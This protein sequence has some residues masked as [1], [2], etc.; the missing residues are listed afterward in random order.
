MSLL[1]GVCICRWIAVFASLAGFSVYAIGVIFNKYR[2]EGFDDDSSDDEDEVT[3]AGP[4]GPPVPG[5]KPSKASSSRKTA[6][7]ATTTVASTKAAA[8]VVST[9][10]TI[11]VGDSS[12]L[13]RRAKRS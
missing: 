12:G 5:G 2:V 10:P 13:R 9:S 7:P 6:E 8:D 1:A 4:K 11:S 3:V